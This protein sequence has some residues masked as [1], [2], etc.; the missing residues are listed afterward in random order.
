M[1]KTKTAF[2]AGVE[3]EKKT[4]KQKYEEK[5]LKKKALEEDTNGEVGTT[6]VPSEIPDSKSDQDSEVLAKSVEKSKKIVEEKRR[7]KKYLESKTKIDKSKNYSLQEAIV[8]VK[9]ASYSKFDG[10]MEI[11]LIVKKVPTTVTVTLP[12]SFG[13][14]KKIE[15]ATDATLEKL[16]KGKIE[17]DVLL[18]TADFMPKLIPFA[19]ILGPRGLMPNPKNGTILKKASDSD[20]FSA[21]TLNL[22]TE[23]EQPLIHTSFGKVSMEDKKLVENAESI[24]KA[25]SKQ[26]V[27]VY[28]KSTMSPSVKLSV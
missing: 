20:K 2:I 22:K 28:M 16:S 23:K 13:K 25:L 10:T 8:A 27:K 17:F 3:E 15:V 6:N 18:T 9:Q 7:G 4:S 12:N 24:L 1:G 14:G 5:R 26:T 11:H 21:N 19:R